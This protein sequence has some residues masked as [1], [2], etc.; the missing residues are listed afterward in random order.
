VINQRIRGG[1]WIAVGIY[2]FE[3]GNSGSILITNSGTNGFVIADAVRLSARNHCN[4]IAVSFNQVPSEFLLSVYPNPF[5]PEA[6]F[7]LKLPVSGL[8]TIKIYDL[9]G[10]EIET[11]AGG[12]YH[13]GLHDIKFDGR[14]LSSGV[15]FYTLNVKTEIEGM[16]NYSSSGK[17][18][19][20]K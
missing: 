2:R 12:N 19:L 8:V 1:E 17:L 20:L 4:P 13:A 9:L 10:R 5:N 14:N 6:N 11:I 15:Y 7:R 18:V 16:K 3:T